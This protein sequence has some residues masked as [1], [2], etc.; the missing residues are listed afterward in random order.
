MYT[1]ENK[2][3]NGWLKEDFYDLVAKII[4]FLISPFLSF[5][6]SL[7]RMNSKS[8]FLVFFLFALFY[9]MCF[10]IIADNLDVWES[11]D[12]AKYRYR[13]EN[14]K[15]YTINDYIDYCKEYFLFV[16]ADVH[17]IYFATVTYFVH[18]FSDNYHVFFM[19]VACVFS[20]FQLKSL[21]YII[22]SSEF[23]NGIQC[24]LLCVLF[25]LNTIAGICA[26]RFWTAAWICVYCIFRLYYDG[27]RKYLIILLLLPLVHRSFFFFDII[28]LLSLTCKYE[29][30]WKTLYFFSFLFSGISVYIMRDATQYLP[31][32]FSHMIEGYTEETIYETYSVTKQFLTSLSTIYVN[33]LFLILF[34]KKNEISSN[35]LGLARFTLV[36]LTIINFVFPIP[37]LGER[38]IVLSYSL[39]A[40]L[41]LNIMGTKNKYNLLIYLMPLFMGRRLYLDFYM[42]TKYQSVSFFYTNPIELIYS[43]IIQ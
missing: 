14:T 37:S 34:W 6:Y 38:F 10:S 42:L 1:T 27:K 18:L 39:V 36:Y 28:L 13:F 40:F 4:T 29:K 19:T 25:S 35:I 12:A 5:I 33:L 23:D 17:D 21:R 2:A 8:S 22:K 7:K 24:F 32:I 30:M 43:C 15:I 11:N 20:F 9:G 41:W 31:S 3:Y 16:G 26:F